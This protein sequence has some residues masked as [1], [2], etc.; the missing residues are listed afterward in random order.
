MNRRS[1]V[2]FLL[3]LFC[4]WNGFAQDVNLSLWHPLDTQRSDSTRYSWLNVGLYSGMHSLQGLGVNVLASSVKR[5][6]KGLQVSGFSNVVGRKM[7]GMQLSG[8]CNVNRLYMAGVSAS[9]LVTINSNFTDGVLLSGAINVSGGRMRG[10]ACAGLMNM[11]GRS[12]AGMFVSGMSNILMGN[13]KGLSIGGLANVAGY[14]MRGVS[15]AG[16]AT[17]VGEMQR[18]LAV[19]GLMN[20]CGK[21]VH[22]MQMA[23]FNYADS[24][25]GLQ[26]G[27]VNYKKK[28]GGFQLG[29]VNLRPDTEFQCLI[30]GGNTA[31]ANVG[32]RIKNGMWYTMLGIGSNYLDVHKKYSASV[33]YRAGVWTNLYKGLSASGD[34]GFQHI[35]TFKNRLEGEIPARMYGLQARVNLEY[36]IVRHFG[37]FASC[38]YGWDRYYT[39]NRTF[40]QGVIG[41]FGIVLQ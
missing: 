36:Q 13:T 26:L 33:F 10:M 1:W 18:G 39:R 30:F 4:C 28:P 14:S 11:A 21:E 29:L 32:V 9:G 40:H 5:D 37:V 15:L 16:L 38:G 25:K 23:L 17:I 31:K 27:L 20:V 2:C 12:S 24:L 34:L 19:S 3:T 6:A 41:E 7:L 8:I 35:E 22:G